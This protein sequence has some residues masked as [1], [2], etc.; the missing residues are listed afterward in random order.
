MAEQYKIFKKT[1]EEE[2]PFAY[3]IAQTARGLKKI[4]AMAAWS[5]TEI[6]FEN[7]ERLHKFLEKYEASTPKYSEKLQKRVRKFLT[8]VVIPRLGRMVKERPVFG[9][10]RAV[11][12][13]YSNLIAL[14]IDAGYKIFIVLAGTTNSLLCKTKKEWKKC[15]WS[16]KPRSGQM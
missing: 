9:M 12:T 14:G 13:S 7:H 2:N 1:F 15:Y 3:V 6:K 8:S 10:Y 16:N 4:Q 5:V 11:T